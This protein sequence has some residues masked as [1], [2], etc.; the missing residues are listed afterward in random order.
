MAVFPIHEEVIIMT[1]VLKRIS[2][3]AMAAAMAT[4]MAISASAAE[5]K[6]LNEPFLN[7]TADGYITSNSYTNRVTVHTTYTSEADRM[8][9]GADVDY[10]AS[11]DLITRLPRTPGYN[12]DA[13]AYTSPVISVNEPITVF[14]SHEIFVGQE[15][16]GEYNQLYSVML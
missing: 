1:K 2:A 16:W 11:G 10:T 12:T 4:T 3:V 7:G 8:Y 15:V 6:H 13:I 14:S 9:V 5:S